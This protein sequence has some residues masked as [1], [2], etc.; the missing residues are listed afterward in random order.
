MYEI[1]KSN[2]FLVN[3]QWHITTISFK[4]GIISLWYGCHSSP[5]TWDVGNL[6]IKTL[7]NCNRTHQKLLVLC[8]LAQPGN[9]NLGRWKFMNSNHFVQ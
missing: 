5:E 2:K 9:Q 3:M 6:E 8:S 4:N 1:N 7:S